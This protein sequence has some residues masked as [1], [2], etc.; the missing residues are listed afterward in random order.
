M[1]ETTSPASSRTTGAVSPDMM[2]E[3]ATL[4]R[5]TTAPIA[6]FTLRTRDHIL[7]ARGGHDGLRLYQDLARDGHAG[8]VLR[9]RRQ[10]VI[11]REWTVDPGGTS[12]ADKQA[13][14]LARAVLKRIK[15]DEACRGLLGATLTGIAVAEI[16][17]GPV[18]IDVPGAGRRTWI[19][20]T[21]IKPRS[22]RRFV[23]DRDEKLRLLTR[24]QPSQGEALPDRKFIFP[25]FWAETN[26]DPYGRGLGH[27]LFWPVYFK[28]NG[29]AL[30][31]ALLEKFGQPFVYA[32]A[33]MGL[34]QGDREALAQSLADIARGAGLVVPAGT[35]IKFLEAMHAGADGSGHA[36]LVEVMNAEISKIVLGETLTTE[37]GAVGSRAASQTHDGVRDELAD[38]DGDLLSGELNPTLMTW[39][40]QVNLP[41]AAPPT[42]WR[43]K[44]EAVDHAA[45]AKLDLDLFQLGWEPTDGEVRTFYG[46]GYV[47]RNMP[48]VMDP[49][50]APGAEPPATPAAFAEPDEGPAEATVQAFA[51]RTQAEAAAAER[52]IMDAVRTELGQAVD[53]ADA[54]ARLLRLA[55]VLPVAGLANT[56][57]DA[58][59]A[60]QLAGRADAA[61]R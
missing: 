3:I 13:A 41:G 9:K 33:P 15:F 48:A 44:A 6:G 30:W 22:A 46:T 25:R 52:A 61:R 57:A 36:K 35:L 59:T 24:E 20:P 7:L 17:W 2:T 27:D 14:E 40:T 53:M 43:R 49:V 29:M 58:I 42:V 12:R 19:V 16:I 56:L 5:D 10:A 11:A 60:A 45:R 32:E 8:S 23:F 18:E 47:R 21:A 26:E 31:N 55:S 28:R 1:S 4:L 39:L 51:D 38:Q 37:M 34:P 54:E 50:A